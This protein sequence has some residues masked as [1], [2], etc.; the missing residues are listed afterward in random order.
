VQRDTQRRILRIGVI[1]IRLVGSIGVI[2]GILF[3]L[4][5]ISVRIVLQF[6]K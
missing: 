5:G 4:I 1:V 2:V 3:G 6:G